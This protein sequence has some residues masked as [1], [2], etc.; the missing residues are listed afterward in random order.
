M[1]KENLGSKTVALSAEEVLIALSICA[2]TN[3]MV[4]LCLDQLERLKGCQAHSTT[5]LS[6]SDE[7]CLQKLGLDVT[8]DPQYPSHNLY[9][10][11]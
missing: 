10:N 4:Q 11:S 1:K 5:I 9:Y 2:T 8:C 3:P 7:S 6:H